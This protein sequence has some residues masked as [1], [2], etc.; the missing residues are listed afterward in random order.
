MKHK[1]MQVMKE[2]EA[3]KPVVGCI[4]LDDARG[5]PVC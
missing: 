3:T 2:R 5:G 4:Q 1:L